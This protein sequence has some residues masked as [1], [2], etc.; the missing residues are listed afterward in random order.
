VHDA[1]Y[2]IV[3]AL[4]NYILDFAPAEVEFGYFKPQN[5]ISV[6]SSCRPNDFPE[7]QLTKK[8]SAAAAAINTKPFCNKKL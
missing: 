1:N 8:C 5:L 4:L 2:S 6:G 3:K 7:N